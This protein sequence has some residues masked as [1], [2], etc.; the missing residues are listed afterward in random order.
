MSRTLLSSTAAAIFAFQASAFAEPATVTADLALRMGPGLTYP[1]VEVMFPDTVVEI[2]GCVDRGLWCRVDW[3]GQRGWAY[4]AFLARERPEPFSSAPPTMQYLDRR[5]PAPAPQ[6]WASVPRD[7]APPAP[8]REITVGPPANVEAYVMT[9]K[10]EPI[11]L[12]GE[13]VVD[14]TLPVSVKLHQVPGY[15]YRY[16]YINDRVVL[17]DPDTYRIV[18]VF[19]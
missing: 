8:A 13:A 5:P 7:A 6:Q 17:A 15:R 18:H 16:A 11:R 12:K 14:A 3:N 2:E 10:V 1:V 4:A 19:Q 9:H